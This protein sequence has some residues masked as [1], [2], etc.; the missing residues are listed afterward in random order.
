MD[1]E[2]KIK[3]VLSFLATFF[4]ALFLVE[5]FVFNR[6]FPLSTAG[7]LISAVSLAVIELYLRIQHSIKNVS[8]KIDSK[9]FFNRNLI[10]SESN[11]INGKIDCLEA[12]V[13]KKFFMMK[14]DMEFKIFNSKFDA[15]NRLKLIEEALKDIKQEQLSL[16]NQMNA[17]NFWP[18]EE[19]RDDTKET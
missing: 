18:E 11:K 15:E 12:E 7:I 1:I 8:N 2:Q 5:F 6:S 9:F 16:K 14:N 4:I 3:F 13:L 10:N 17:E 19:L